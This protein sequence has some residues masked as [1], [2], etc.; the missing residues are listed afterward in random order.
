VAKLKNNLF[1]GGNIVG[2]SSG[3]KPIAHIVKLKSLIFLDKR[4]TQGL[5][6]KT[7]QTA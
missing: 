6:A 5:A 2:L 7:S 4:K 3:D 1:F